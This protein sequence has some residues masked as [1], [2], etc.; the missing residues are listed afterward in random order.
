MLHFDNHAPGSYEGRFVNTS[1]DSISDWTPSVEQVRDCILAYGITAAKVNDEAIPEAGIMNGYAPTPNEVEAINDI[2]RAAVKAGRLIDFGNLPNAFMIEHGYRGKTFYSEGWIGQPF[3]DPWIGMHRW[4]QG[5]SVY[6][7]ALV[8]GAHPAGGHCEIVEFTPM[9]VSGHPFLSIG[10]RLLF[11]PKPGSKDGDLNAMVV[12]AVA[13][14]YG[15][16]IEHFKHAAMA[17]ADNIITP[18]MTMLMIL[19]TDGIERELRAPSAKLARAREK[20]GKPPIPPHEVVKTQGY[21][22]AVI[23]RGRGVKGPAQGGHHASPIPHLRRGHI[24]NLASGQRT[25]IRDTLVNMNDEARAA[26]ARSHYK[27]TDRGA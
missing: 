11:T 5:V 1:T 15:K 8:E 7:V 9:L 26:I 14:L 27:T 12:P 3:V 22:T 25:F 2:A 21:V 16:P 10:D 23:G 19:N 18:L 4:E 6:V 17:A 20:S 13:R 24:R